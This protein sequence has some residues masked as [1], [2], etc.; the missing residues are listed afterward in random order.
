MLLVLWGSPTLLRFGC[1]YCPLLSRGSWHVEWVEQE[2]R[3]PNGGG[4]IIYGRQDISDKGDVTQPN[5]GL[6][7]PIED[8]IIIVDERE[9]DN[10]RRGS[11]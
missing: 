8:P 9:W 1:V 5:G 10:L 7:G 11:D 3:K 4:V 2:P 6:R